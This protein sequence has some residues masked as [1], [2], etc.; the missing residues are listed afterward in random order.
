[1]PRKGITIYDLLISCP[2]DVTEYVETIKECVESFN[3]GIGKLNNIEVDIKHWSK[4]S[5]PES[6]DKP[7]ELLNKQFVRDCDVA[8]AIFGTRF[9]TPTDKYGSGTEEEIHEMLSAE[10]QVFMYF[11]D[12]L[13]EA[14]KIDYE[15]YKKVLEFKESY[16]EIGLFDVIKSKEEFERKFTNHLTQHFLSIISPEDNLG[17]QALRP[18]LKIRDINTSSDNEF[19]LTTRHLLDSKFIKEIKDDIVDDIETL[20]EFVLPEIINDDLCSSE[21]NIYDNSSVFE[22]DNGAFKFIK[23]YDYVELNKEWI[24]VIKD[25][26]KHNGIEINERFW[27]LGNLKS[28]EHP[29]FPTYFG[30]SGISYLGSEDEKKRY[31]LLKELYCI[32]RSY[33]EYIEYFT[34]IDNLNIM[35]LIVSNIGNRYDEDLEVKLI[36]PKGY[37]IKYENLPAPGMN[38]IGKLIDTNFMD[39]VFSI[40]ERDSYSKYENFESDQIRFRP[41][42]ILPPII[43]KSK[44]EIYENNK[45][46]YRDILD[47][48]FSYKHFENSNSDILIF[49]IKYLKHNSSMAFPSVLMFKEKPKVIEYEI[50]SKFIPEITKGKICIEC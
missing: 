31:S 34:Y 6:G 4:D 33:N 7:Q 11:V 17:L 49:K 45:S 1:M 50:T 28:Y 16:K 36:I 39:A 20:K 13:V 3:R 5:Y 48:I 15:Q 22:S 23:A 35:E 40:Q 2:G 41:D 14:S 42:N 43:K 38:T 21:E 9:G 25:F 44:K 19:S 27:Y 18:F 26:A 10:K 30:E 47:S 37:L 32:I 24:R 46:E 8:V 12:P 29:K